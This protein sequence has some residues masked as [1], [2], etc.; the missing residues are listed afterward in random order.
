MEGEGETVCAQLT[1]LWLY[2]PVFSQHTGCVLDNIAL[3]AAKMEELTFCILF[4]VTQTRSDTLLTSC[5]YLLESLANFQF[6][7]PVNDHE[8]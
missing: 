5:T 2:Y 4:F 6:I 3:L 7:I 1:D 8:L